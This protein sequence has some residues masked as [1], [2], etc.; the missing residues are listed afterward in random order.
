PIMK[1][2]NYTDVASP[3]GI[4]APQPSSVDQDE[5][6][7]MLEISEDIQVQIDFEVFKEGYPL[8]AGFAI[9]M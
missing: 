5:Y 3:T 1:L 8:V 9:I 6:S 2:A 4:S 7:I